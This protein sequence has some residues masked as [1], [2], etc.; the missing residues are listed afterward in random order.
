M[1]VYGCVKIWFIFFIT[2]FRLTP[3][4]ACLMLV[5]SSVILH[6]GQG[7]NWILVEKQVQGCTENW[8]KNLL[9]INNMFK[10]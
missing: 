9:Y 5:F 3:A 2:Y 1:F 10:E 8:W 6:V 7:P 4:Y